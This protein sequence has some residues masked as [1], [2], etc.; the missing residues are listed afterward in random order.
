MPRYKLTI[1]YDGTPFC[2]WQK[3]EDQ[4]SVQEV[5]EIACGTFAGLGNEPVKVQCSGRTDAG[6]HA[7]GQVAHVDFPKARNPFNIVQGLNVLMHHVPVCVVAAEE[8]AD[9]FNARFDA[10]MRH[11]EYRIINRSPTLA[12]D[13]KRAMHVFQELDIEAMQNAAKHLLG[14]HDFSSFRAAACQGKNP[15]K[16]L[17][18]LDISQQSEHVTITAK[19]RSFL[20]HQVRNITG[21]LVYVGIGKFTAD[22]VKEILDARD[23]RKAGPTAPAHGLYFMGVSYN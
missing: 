1:E 4:Q 8:V 6:V 15:I 10:T 17:E 12:L 19:S 5:V 13:A 21:T 22:D 23:R 11:Y 7:Y 2:G 16:T 18:A 3:Q 20:H 9:D 14:K